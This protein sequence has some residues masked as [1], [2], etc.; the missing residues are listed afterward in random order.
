MGEKEAKC[1]SIVIETNAR[2]VLLYIFFLSPLARH[3]DIP[4]LKVMH[5]EDF[6][7]LPT[8]GTNWVAFYPVHIFECMLK[9][10]DYILI[11]L[12][13]QCI[14]CVIL[15]SQLSECSIEVFISFVQKMLF[16]FGSGILLYYF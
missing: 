13:C 14:S 4:F 12:C 2:R 15:L 7:W 16:I 6:I 3:L 9:Q 8:N 1:N 11:A 10:R 5:V